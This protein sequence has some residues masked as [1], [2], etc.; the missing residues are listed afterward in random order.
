MSDLSQVVRLPVRRI[1]LELD[2]EGSARIARGLRAHVPGIAEEAVARIERQLPEFVR[3]HDPRY[4]KAMLLAVECAIGHFLD[5]MAEPGTAPPD[6]PEFW[7]QIGAGEAGEGRTLD[8]WQAA[9]RIGMG[10]AVERLTERAEQLGYRTSPATIAGIT[11]AVLG[12]LNQVAAIVSEGHADAAAQAAGAR[13]DHRR[14]LLDL[15][16]NDPS[17]K[18]LRVPAREADWP[19]PRTVAAVALRERGPDTRHPVLPPDV[20]LGLHLAEPCLVVPDPEGPGRGR[21]LERQLDGW[22]ASIGPA[23]RL[24]EA[25]ASLRLARAALK[26]ADQGL[27]GGDSPI[28]AER[29]MPIIVMMRERLLV[30]KVVARRLAPLLRARPAQ[31]YRLAETLLTCLECGFN[32]TEVS[33]HLHLHPQTVRY[34][35]RQL[36]ELFGDDMHATSDR[37]ELHMALRA[38]LALNGEPGRAWGQPGASTAQP[39]AAIPE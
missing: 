32:A 22:T 28:A 18:E 3:P 2:F 13:Q 33:G 11:N 35:L 6:V 15:L 27:I 31:R 12:Y 8:S 7:R 20:L 24:T 26:L 23:V 10:L 9:T 25:A 14:H 16:L 19:L 36:E 30:E 34:R 37:L 1:E 4:A 17:P 5:L 29:H 39:W 21:M 38:W